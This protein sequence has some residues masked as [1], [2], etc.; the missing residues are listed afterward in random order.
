MV[1]KLIPKRVDENELLDSVDEND[2]FIE[3]TTKN[4][5]FLNN[6]IT[7]NV[8]IF[9]LDKD[10]R[11]LITKRSPKK[12]S[13]PNRYDLA[14]CGNVKSGED[15][16]EAASREVNEEL[17][18]KC[19]L[20]F[21]GK[22]FNKFDE[23]NIQL[24]YFTGIFIGHFSGEVRLNDELVE[25]CKLSVEEVE[26]M[27]N[28]NKELF[29]PGFVND[30]LYAKDKLKQN[31][32]IIMN[33]KV[34]M[35]IAPVDFRDEEYF[36]TRKILEDV[37]NKITVVNSTGQPSKSSFGK[38]VR[39]DKTIHDIDAN[40]FDAIVFVGGSG[41]RVYFDN[42]QILSLAKEFNKSG[43]V[44]AAICIGPSILVNAGVLNGKKATS[45]PSERDNINAVGTFTGKA[46]E[47][48]GKIITANGP[49]A[50][51]EFGKKISDALK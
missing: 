45:F 50:A 34:L 19:S 42:Q 2:N 27:I 23:N 12:K 14:A 28:E 4:N 26:G 7:R 36:E 16:V 44:V 31:Q 47:Q 21:L 8:A 10:G 32:D 18:M 35:V 37:G 5:K 29:T 17:D 48:D 30:F 15:Y 49:Q 39:V 20:N 11:L 41:T 33:K 43:K 6:L 9:I 1:D 25:S 3:Q 22:I 40:D 38:I 13:F 46:V 51:K 24:R